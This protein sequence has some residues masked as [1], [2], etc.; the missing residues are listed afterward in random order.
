MIWQFIPKIWSNSRKLF[1]FCNWCFTQWIIII[2]IIIFHFENF[3]LFHAKLGSNVCPRVDNQTSGDT[4]QGL[5]RPI[6]GK[7]KIFINQLRPCQ[8]MPHWGKTHWGKIHWSNV[9]H[10]VCLVSSARAPKTGAR[11]TE[12]WALALL[13]HW[14]MN[15]DMYGQVDNIIYRNLLYL[16]KFR[17][18]RII[19]G[20]IS[21]IFSNYIFI[22]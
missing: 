20:Q 3:A 18:I 14:G 1:W 9:C 10:I 21:H 7:G 6:S 4:L 22:R 2:I 16:W 8:T 13:P 19:S 12:A 17:P 5:T 15:I 11:L